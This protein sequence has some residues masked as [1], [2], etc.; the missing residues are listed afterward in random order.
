MI[1]EQ[2]FPVFEKG[3]MLKKDALDLLRDYAPDYASLFFE[4]YGD[5]IL[6]GFE[7][8]GFQDRI[9]IKPGILKT[10]TTFFFL[11]KEAVLEVMSFGEPTMVLV[12]KASL[13]K[14]PDFWTQSYELLTAPVREV[15]EG[16]TE[17][18]RFRLEKGAKLRGSEDYKDFND[19]TTEYNTV[20]LISVKHACENGSSLSPVILNMYAKGVIGSKKAEPLDLSFAVACLNNPRVSVDLLKGYLAA[21]D[22]E[23][24]EGNKEW[25]RSLKRLYSSLVSGGEVHRRTGKAFGKTVID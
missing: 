16:E 14:T 19:L 7:L 13:K 25:F 17:L 23:A 24:G 6:S 22:G 15:E 11:K 10:G 18:G 20:N 8:S 4:N 12:K 3:R 1:V 21:R 9:L 2:R 5:G